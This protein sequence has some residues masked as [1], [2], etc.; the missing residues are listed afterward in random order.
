MKQYYKKS[1]PNKTEKSENAENTDNLIYGRHPVADAIRAKKGFEKVYFQLGL[2]GEMEVE[3]RHLCRDAGIPLSIVPTERL[4]ALTNGANHQGVVGFLSVVE[5]QSLEN[6]LPMLFE[7]GKTPLL[8][9]LDGVT[10]VRNV[11]AIARSAEVLGAHALVLP[12]QG[13]AAL[14]ADAMKTSAG[15]LAR[16]P[17]CR[18]KTLSAALDLLAASGVRV[19]AGDLKATTP[20]HQIDFREATAILIGSEDKGV[21]PALLQRVDERFIIPQIGQS[22]SLNVS[23]ATGI[24]L[25]EASKQRNDNA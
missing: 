13:S 7:D 6:L 4:N 25:Y 8:L 9:L 15:A 12:L 23:V 2:R 16:L 22:D 3:F 5:Y 11:G 20:M 10:D 17:I 18:A 14:N 21:S 1:S 24:M 19:V